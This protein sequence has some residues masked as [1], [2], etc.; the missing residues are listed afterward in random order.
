[1][2]DL[3]PVQEGLVKRIRD[4]FTMTSASLKAKIVRIRITEG[5]TGLFF[6]TSPDLKGLLVAEPTFDGLEAAIPDAI[7][8]MY[9]AYDLDVIVGRAESGDDGIAP[10]VAMPLEIARKSLADVR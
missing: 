3:L 2:L 4:Q 7:R 8:E 1:V 10:W 5:K 6:A 9:A